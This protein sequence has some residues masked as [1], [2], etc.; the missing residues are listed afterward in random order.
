MPEGAPSTPLGRKCHRRL[1]VPHYGESATGGSKYLTMGKVPKG[2]PLWESALGAESSPMGKG[3][4]GL[5]LPLW[6]RW[7]VSE[8]VTN[9]PLCTR[10]LGIEHLTLITLA[11]VPK[12][13][14]F[15]ESFLK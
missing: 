11:V 13:T 4:I 3:P 1:Q 8:G 6:G 5:E 2:A 9:T 10:G 14:H 15:F 7:Q 12:C